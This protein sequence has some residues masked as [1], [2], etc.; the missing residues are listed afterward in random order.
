MAIA[1]VQ[2]AT[3]GQSAA[4]ATSIST[5]GM[6]TTAGNFGV[7]TWST[8]KSTTPTGT[9]VTDSKGNTPTQ[10]HVT[11]INH[12][13]AFDVNV[14]MAYEQIAS[15]GAGHTVTCSPGSSQFCSISFGEYS[16]VA[17]S[18]PAEAAGASDV[19]GNSVSANPGAVNPAS[20][21]DLY[22]SACTH[23]GSGITFTA[24]ASWTRR[25][26]LGD[27]G[28]SKMPLCTTEI[29]ASGSQTGTIT[30]SGTAQWAAI[31]ATFQAGA[32]AADTREWG[33]S[34]PMARLMTRPNVMY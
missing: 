25:T 16:G 28:G 30:L 31:V 11:S 32:A 20:A 29:I 7:I 26:N 3:P 15:G 12:N 13:G 34:Y 6:T 8:D 9:V 14:G 21:N 1:H 18:S 2:H 19:T 27:A 5:T 33:G 23:A 24:A 22:Y 17:T 4:A 10:N